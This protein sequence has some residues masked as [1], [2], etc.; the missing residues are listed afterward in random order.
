MG[1]TSWKNT[2]KGGKVLRSDV[3]VAKNYLTKAE[4]DTLNRLVSMYLDMAEL[5]ATKQIPTSMEDWEKRLESFLIFN[6]LDCLEGP[7]TISADKAK[8]HALSE[9]EKFRVRQDRQFESDFDTL[10]SADNLI[11]QIKKSKDISE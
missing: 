8:D 4:L 3:V 9:Y 6:E 1:L 7:G 5:R 11:A 10:A 2:K